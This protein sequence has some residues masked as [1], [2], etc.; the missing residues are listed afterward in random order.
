MSSIPEGS[1]TKIVNIYPA[2]GKSVD[3]IPRIKPAIIGFT[4]NVLLTNQE[5]LNVIQDGHKVV[6]LDENGQEHNLNKDNATKELKEIIEEEKEAA[7]FAANMSA[8]NNQFVMAQI[9]QLNTQLNVAN[10]N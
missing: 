3:C 6:M 9:N 1:I 2:T 4:P 5:I 7:E 10:A 8:S